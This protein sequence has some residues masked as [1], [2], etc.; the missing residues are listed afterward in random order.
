MHCIISNKL[1]SGVYYINFITK[2]GNTVEDVRAHV[3]NKEDKFF[4]M[5]LL[6]EWI[7]LYEFKSLIMRQFN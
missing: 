4:V 5:R 1:P 3:T 7:K 2:L 6:S